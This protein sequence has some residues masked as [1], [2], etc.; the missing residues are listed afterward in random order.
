MSNCCPLTVTD[1]MVLE[2]PAVLTVMTPRAPVVP[3]EVDVTRMVRPLAAV[4]TTSA[5]ITTSEPLC[6]AVYVAAAGRR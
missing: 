5:A 3:V 4:P 2:L 6:V 1:V